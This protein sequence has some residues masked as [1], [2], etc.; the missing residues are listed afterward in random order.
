MAPPMW[1]LLEMGLGLNCV[2]RPNKMVFGLLG[3]YV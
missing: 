2:G 1:M 3:A